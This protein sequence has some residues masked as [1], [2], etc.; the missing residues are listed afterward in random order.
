MMNNLRPA[1]QT[2][3]K[4]SSVPNAKFNLICFPYAGAG[5]STYQ[6]WDNLLGAEIEVQGVN[7]PGREERL[8]EPRT[9]DLDFLVNDIYENISHFLDNR[10]FIFYGHSLGALVAFELTRLLRKRGNAIP[11]CL[12][13]GARY[14]PQIPPLGAPI[15]PLEED[16]FIEKVREY[17]SALE[18]LDD[19]ELRRA[20]TPV[21]K[22]D[23]AVW[24]N[25]QY[26]EDEPLEI[27]IIT[28]GG[29]IDHKVPA[30]T[31]EAWSSQTNSNFESIRLPGGHFFL[32][33]SRDIMLKVLKSRLFDLLSINS[34]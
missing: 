23:F 18:G 9:R 17:G 27:P 2:L 11:R 31:L 26:Q 12:V 28:F 22:D 7:Y 13:I 3:I 33:E 1:S 32:E 29:M 5:A 20:L 14:A 21:L 10:P 30:P 34:N 19:M 8:D 4:Y 24:E 6:K 25:Y 15:H 16:K